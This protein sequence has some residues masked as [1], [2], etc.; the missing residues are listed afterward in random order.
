MWSKT[1]HTQLACDVFRYVQNKWTMLC[2]GKCNA[3]AHKHIYNVICKAWCMCIRWNVVCVT[4]PITA[5]VI[6]KHTCKVT[7]R[8]NWQGKGMAALA[9]RRDKLPDSSSFDQA[10]TR[11][12][13]VE[14]YKSQNHCKLFSNLSPILVLGTEKAHCPWFYLRP[15]LTTL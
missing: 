7:M 6:W 8:R 12:A 14:D 10:V 4:T 13:Q 3:K 1:S 9:R 11:Q 2:I 5:S 15:S